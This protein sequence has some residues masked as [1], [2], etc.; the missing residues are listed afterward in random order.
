MLTKFGDNRPNSLGST[1]CDIHPDVR[2]SGRPT[3]IFSRCDIR[4]QEKKLHL[5]ASLVQNRKLSRSQDFPILLYNR[6]VKNLN[7]RHFETD[8]TALILS[9]MSNRYVRNRRADLVFQDSKKRVSAVR[10]VV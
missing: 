10:V 9:S 4:N 3:D 7:G 8:I 1:E 5:V 2:T 6:K